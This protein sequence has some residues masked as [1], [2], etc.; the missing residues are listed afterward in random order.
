MLLK[1]GKE[2]NIIKV[3]HGTIISQNNHSYSATER[4]EEILFEGALYSLDLMIRKQWRKYLVWEIF[5]LFIY[6]IILYITVNPFKAVYKKY[7][8]ISERISWYLILLNDK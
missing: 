4:G 3:Q 2:T 5:I 7:E 1:R 8:N 6:Y